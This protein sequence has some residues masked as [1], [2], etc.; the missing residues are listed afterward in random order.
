MK[1][2]RQFIEIH[3]ATIN[4]L[5][6]FFVCVVAYGI[7]IPLLGFYW[8]DWPTIFYT[9]NQRFAQL[10]NHFSYDR[11]FSV[12]A[13]WVV[14]QLSTSPLVWQVTALLLRF[15]TALGVGWALEPL[16]PGHTK[17]ILY[18]A[19]LFAV[20]P[21]YY[22]QPSSVIFVPHLAALALF[23]LSLGAMG[24]AAL[25]P[26]WT[27]MAIGT[28]AA[29]AQIFTVEYFVG[30]ELL[31]PLYLWLLLANHGT[32]KPSLKRVAQLWAPYAVILVA[33]AAWR[34]FL[35]NLPTEPYPIVLLSELG[36]EPLATIGHLTLTILLDVQYTF[37]QVW[38]NL[39]QPM[40]INLDTRFGV[41]T[42]AICAASAWAVYRVLSELPNR[43]SKQTEPQTDLGF[44]RQGMALGLAAFVLGM[45]PVW[46]IGETIAQGDYNVRYILVGMLGAAL[47]VS[48]I[49]VY[50]VPVGAHRILII[51]LLAGLALGGHIQTA[52]AYRLDWEA[53]RRFYW[54]LFWRAPSF[55]SNTALVSFERV[56]KYL[57]DPMTGNA[58][59]VLYPSAGAE[60]YV[61]LWNFELNRTQTVNTIMAGKPLENDYRGLRFTAEAGNALVL[62]Y[63]P[64]NGCLWVLGPQDVQNDYLP[65]EN[66]ELVG[67]SN[68]DRIRGA[69]ANTPPAYIF[70]AEP[71]ATWCYYFEK[72]DLARQQG[73]WQTVIQLMTKAQAQGLGPNYGIEW[74][75]LVDAYIHTADLPAAIELSQRIHTMHSR[76]DRA[77]CTLWESATS[78]QTLEFQEAYATV[79][80]IA[81]CQN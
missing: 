37:V 20:Y 57:G 40:L 22:V 36:R 27:Y 79:A 47:V 70:G 45:L 53:Q 11:P 81:H 41:L 38:A 58:L 1:P 76:S 10:V 78:R 25:K 8:D 48:S 23:L 9:Y 52:E 7:F 15:A 56:S 39:F 68:L 49:L 28:G 77:L 55:E 2:I 72:A 80:E 59:N 69:N 16:W 46:A 66:R 73:E 35:L 32:R 63:L 43:V 26:S 24:R 6:L 65:F 42:L 34:L 71:T 3:P 30:L 14:G 13:Y 4:P 62:Y 64:D 75:P 18:V 33:W 54:Q 29:A 12:W 44:A 21:G 50:F 61:G 17:K 31:R 74:L 19:L 5:I 51:S 60:P 67:Y